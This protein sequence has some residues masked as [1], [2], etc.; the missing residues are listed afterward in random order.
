[1]HT[2]I[3]RRQ[4]LSLLAAAGLMPHALWAQGAA[5]F[6][7]ALLAQAAAL[8]DAALSDTHGYRL[9]ESLVTEIGARPVGSANYARAVDWAL[10]Q[11]RAMGFANVRAES[12]PAVAWRQGAVSAEITA[13]FQQRLVAVALGNSVG[14]P[15]GGLEADVAYYPTLEALKTD[16]SERA[17]GRIVFID[18]KMERHKDGHGYGVAVVARVTSAMEAARKGAV[19]VVIRS[20]GTDHDRV[21][22]TGATRYD[23]Q[24]P[25]IPAL[26]VSVP[27]ADMVARMQR[28]GRPLVMRLNLQTETGV[29]VTSHNVIAEVPGTDLADEVVMV[30]GHL[31]S[32]HVGTGAIDD[33]AGVAIMAAAAKQ[34]L[35]FGKP[36]RRT[37]RVV[38]FANEEN[39][40]EGAMAYAERYKAVRHQLVGE[41]DFG[42]GKVWRLSSKAPEQA[43]P[44]LRQIAQLLA[45]LGVE[46]GGNDGHGGSDVG[47]G[48][49]KY[50]WPIVDLTQDGTNYFDWHHTDN[51]TLDKIDP[52]AMAQN[53]SAWAVVCFMAAQSGVRFS[54]G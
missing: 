47:F 46:A 3:S 11:L 54:A 41:S 49:R 31:D 45:P 1:M 33:G 22:H 29:A 4:S 37:L 14:T 25:K 27:D 7:P 17:K 12:M 39:G 9:V 10:A 40:L 8:R 18:Q 26:A 53:V 50:N 6:S 15:A 21:A 5:P 34:V 42:A 28:L 16:T 24:L 36:L 52:A 30:G 51:D 2:K 32:W 48:A 19:A 43:L 38:F 35:D 20:I 13:P 44:A 23:P